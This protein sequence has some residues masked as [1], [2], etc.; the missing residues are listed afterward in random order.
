MSKM[1]I[2]HLFDLERRQVQIEDALEGSLATDFEMA[3]LW[4]PSEKISIQIIDVPTAPRRKWREIIPWMLEDIVLQNVSDIHYEIIDE[5]S[6]KLTLLIISTECL[7]NWQRIAKNAAVNA[8]SMAPDYLAVPFDKN[9]ISVGWREGVLLVR[10]SRINGFAAKP[11]LAW[12]L[13]ERFLDEN[14]N[15]SLSISIPD[16]SLVPKNLLDSAKVN[17]SEIDWTFGFD[18]NINVLPSQLKMNNHSNLISKWLLVAC[19]IILSFGVSL[20]SV[21]VGN[22]AME[23]QI[24]LYET[25]NVDLFKKIFN[26]KVP[27]SSAL[28]GKAESNIKRLFEQNEA[29][30]SPIMRALYALQPLMTNCGC[31]LVEMDL[32]E[33]SVELQIR[34][35][36][37]LIKRPLKVDGYK[38]VIDNPESSESDVVKIMMALEAD[39][40]R[41]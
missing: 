19:I 16:T 24:E 25:S 14:S 36:S 31:E 38:I 6:G 7:E 1:N 9:T 30:N 17:N 4:V 12:P 27:S 29:L 22:N 23:K 15:F 34:N 28:R 33:S 11:S 39:S 8:I 2:I 32:S 18:E 37:S 40:N 5:N 35:A 20:L 21:W 41:A 26:Q 10:T 13:I 3:K